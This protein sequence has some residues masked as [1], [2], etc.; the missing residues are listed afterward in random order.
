M[1]AVV[2]SVVVGANSM[3]GRHDWPQ[4]SKFFCF[5]HWHYCH[6]QC[7]R[8]CTS[9]RFRWFARSNVMLPLVTFLLSD[10]YRSVTDAA[11]YTNRQCRLQV[12]LT[13]DVS[14]FKLLGFAGC[15]CKYPLLSSCSSFPKHRH[16]F[17]QEVKTDNCL[18]LQKLF[19][20]LVRAL[21]QHL[22]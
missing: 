14:Y 11:D 19:L 17:L 1:Y 22:N 20:R 15:L 7:L 2:A 8:C 10:A 12:G 9:S 18:L 13:R 21:Y 3:D 4:L 5:H 6:I 16:I